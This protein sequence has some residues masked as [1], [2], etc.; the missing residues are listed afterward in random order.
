MFQVCRECL[1]AQG[2]VR[3]LNM[4]GSIKK[5]DINKNSNKQAPVSLSIYMNILKFQLQKIAMNIIK[6]LWMGVHYVRYVLLQ[7]SRLGE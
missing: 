1:S 6:C 7:V 2:L 4:Y 5:K 3:F